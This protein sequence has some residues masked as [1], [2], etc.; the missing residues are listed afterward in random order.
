MAKT[1]TP[2]QIEHK[3]LGGRPLS[4]PTVEALDLAIQLY[5]NRCDPHVEPHMVATG[6]TANGKTLFDTR[7]VLTDQKP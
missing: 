6:V 7:E 4:F 2:E 5:F 1:D 3:H